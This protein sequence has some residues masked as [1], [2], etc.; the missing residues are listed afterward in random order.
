S[1]TASLSWNKL[2]EESRGNGLRKT[3]IFP[4]ALRLAKVIVGLHRGRIRCARAGQPVWDHGRAV[5]TVSLVRSVRCDPLIPSCCSHRFTASMTQV[6]Y[7]AKSC[8]G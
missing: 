3:L 1:L 7:E 2:P 4:L 5:P 8:S 6:I